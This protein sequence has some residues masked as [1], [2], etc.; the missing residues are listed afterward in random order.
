MC[1]SA[2]YPIL[3][4]LE[5]LW[6]YIC[7]SLKGG[8]SI[9]DT[10]FSEYDNFHNI[11]SRILQIIKVFWRENPKLLR[12]WNRRSYSTYHNYLFLQISFYITYVQ[13]S[14][15]YEILKLH[16]I[17]H[18]MNVGRL[19]QYFFIFLHTW[20]TIP[21]MRLHRERGELINLFTVNIKSPHF[22]HEHHEGTHLHISQPPEA[23]IHFPHRYEQTHLP[24]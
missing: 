5:Y 18:F 8:K 2:R 24:L 6:F 7:C 4:H 22:R 11:F 17:H 16:N 14:L 23:W 13:K 19:Q 21:T 9:K 15:L 3:L 1:V 12:V 20:Q 10:W